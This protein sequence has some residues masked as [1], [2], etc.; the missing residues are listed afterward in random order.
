M[1]K[2][3]LMAVGAY[4]LV[5]GASELSWVA[6]GNTTLAAIASWPSLGSLVDPLIG[7]SSSANY[8]EGALDAVTGTGLLWIGLRM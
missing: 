8:M 7:T 2:L 6:T 3:I 4:E 1:L 5:V